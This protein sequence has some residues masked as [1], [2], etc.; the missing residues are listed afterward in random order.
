MNDDDAGAAGEASQWPELKKRILK[1]AQSRSLPKLWPDWEPDGAP[2][3]WGYAVAA[4][5]SLPEELQALSLLAAG[6]TVPKRVQIDYAEAAEA[7]CDSLGNPGL[8][9][10]DFVQILSWAYALPALSERLDERLWWD[11][12][13]RLQTL[14]RSVVEQSGQESLIHLLL[15]GE[16]G[17]VLG[18]QLVD[19]PSCEAL[20]KPATQAA[21]RWFEQG[22]ESI[23]AA[24]AAAGVYSRLSLAAGLRCRCLLKV[25]AKRKLKKTHVSVLWQLATWAAATTNAD[26]TAVFSPAPANALRD[27]T[28]QTGLLYTAAAELDPAA[29]TPA[30]EASLGHS[31]TKGRLAWQVSLP[32]PSLYCESQGLAALLPEWDVR[33][34]R[35]HVDYRNDQFQLQV[36]AGRPMLL[37]G[38]WQVSI[39]S[40]GEEQSACGPWSEV[41]QYSDDDVHYLELEQPWSGE[42]K[43]QRQ[44]MV[45]RDDRCVMLADA[46]ISPPT[47]APTELE[48]TARWEVNDA[49]KSEPEADTWEII[50]GDSK[51][52]ALAIPLA[53]SEWRVG[54]NAGT[55]N[56]AADGSLVL[57]VK[58]NNNLY[59]PLWIDCE[60]S[61][62][63]KPRTWRQLTVAELLRIVTPDEAAAYRIEVGPDQWFVYRSMIG[64]VSRTALGK[65][66]VADFYCGRFNPEDGYTEELV[67]VDDDTEE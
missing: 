23:D 56:V 7:F 10:V 27:D 36:H 39:T 67:T 16:L 40:D 37:S 42:L 58:G 21:L 20:L 59:A 14:Q 3:R 60:R 17:L 30:V 26:G 19:L 28:S 64:R 12:L 33:R 47:A 41:C 62:F 31:K 66:V 25:A 9:P 35:V 48:Y 18:W 65:N 55:F 29:L 4:G 8:T 61:R 34:G 38:Q 1:R 5:D 46:V 24:L 45:V 15:G 52:R 13:N 43:L 22:E 6:Q 2:L 53:L 44:I 54:S 49:I 51:S 57:R 11:L 32:E 50:M 63:N